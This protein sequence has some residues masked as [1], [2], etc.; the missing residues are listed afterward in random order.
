MTVRNFA[1]LFGIVFLLVG[2]LGFVP[3][4]NQMHEGDPNLVLNGY[5][6]GHLLGLF[7]VNLLHNLVHILFGIWGLAVFRSLEG[8][9]MYARG[10]AIIYLVLGVAGLIPRLNTLFGLCPIEGND[11]WLHLLLAAVAAY[12]GFLAPMYEPGS[13]ST[14]TTNSAG[15]SR[16]A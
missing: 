2:I 1:L 15:T 7:H 11:V 14:D 9:R 8:S 12:F 5:G 4:V 13:M 3:G 10:V 16:T 6:T